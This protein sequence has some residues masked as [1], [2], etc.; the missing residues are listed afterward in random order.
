MERI[1]TLGKYR[2]VKTVVDGITFDSKKEAKR[3]GELRMLAV[4]GEIT[5]LKVHQRFPVFLNEIKICTYVSDFTYFPKPD[6]DGN[7]EMVIEDVKGG[8][9]TK[10]PVYKLK[11]AMMEAFYKIR[12]QEV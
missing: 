7:S 11:K 8:N 2:N 9:A 4:A 10:T 3:Y 1:G 12:I 6:D 5:D